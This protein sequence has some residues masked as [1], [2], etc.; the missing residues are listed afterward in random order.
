MLVV[1]AIV[2][3]FFYKSNIESL[4]HS[5]IDMTGD[6]VDLCKPTILI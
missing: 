4:F 5:T 1:L 3:F 6:Y 2:L